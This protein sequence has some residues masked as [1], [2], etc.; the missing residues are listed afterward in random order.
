MT[1]LSPAARAAQ[2]A[3]RRR[4]GQFG[5]QQHSDPEPFPRPAAYPAHPDGPVGRA[6]VNE[7]GEDQVCECGNNTWTNDWMAADRDGRIDPDAQGSSEPDEH[8]VCPD[9]G[10]VYRNADLF[11]AAETGGAP[12]VA[13]YDVSSTEF[14]RDHDRY[15]QEIYGAPATGDLGTA[16]SAGMNDTEPRTTYS[17]LPEAVEREIVEPIEAGGVV[18]DARAAYDIDAIA[19]EVIASDS[20][21]GAA[22][23]SC[24]VGTDEFWQV[25]QRHE[26][27]Q[28]E[29]GDAL[30]ADI[31]EAL[32]TLE[33]SEAAEA[34]ERILD[35]QQIHEARQQAQAVFDRRAATFDEA[36]S[37]ALRSKITDREQLRAELR[38]E[39]DRIMDELEDFDE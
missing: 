33:H 26:L 36:Y 9:C 3:S 28:D 34:A 8:T 31:T 23:F 16:H 25:V 30:D 12:A 1:G 27:Q 17:T 24:A 37:T 5:M 14:R 32:N 7:D 19:D 22:E 38:R 21:A 35:D 15:Q 6:T 20:P 39:R 10:L 18:D 4:N 2:E 11:S 13:R 29:P